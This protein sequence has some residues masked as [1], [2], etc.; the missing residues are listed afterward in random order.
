MRRTFVLILI[1]LGLLSACSDDETK[2]ESVVITVQ[3]GQITVENNQREKIYYF[4]VELNTS[5][6]IN[7]APSISDEIP[8]IAP[9]QTGIIPNEEIAG[10]QAGVGQEAIF[11]F[12]T[13]IKERDTFRPGKVKQLTVTL[14]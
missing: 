4:I 2:P 11:Y 13:A 8:S 9:F 14:L 7:W 5:H 12:W 3:E 10:Y 1:S 6:V